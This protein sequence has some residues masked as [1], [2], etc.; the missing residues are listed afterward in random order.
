MSLPQTRYKR[1]TN[2]FAHALY[3]YK[4]ACTAIAESAPSS[5]MRLPQTR[6]KRVVHTH[7]MSMHIR[8]GLYVCMYLKYF[9]Y[10]H[11]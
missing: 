11:T 7:Y 5:S 6:H 9:R 8:I 3:E 4:Y 10:I 1:V 2:A